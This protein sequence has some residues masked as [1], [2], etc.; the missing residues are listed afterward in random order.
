[1]H[2]LYSQVY[3][4]M[5]IV[6]RMLFVDLCLLQM[7]LSHFLCTQA[8]YAPG[9]AT[10]GSVVPC[11][12]EMGEFEHPPISSNEILFIIKFVDD[13]GMKP[14]WFLASGIVVHLEY[15]ASS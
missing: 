7:P 15:L 3:W 12:E 2:S 9:T 10:G 14:W 8:T 11:R 6:S 5:V 1:M 4:K 13:A